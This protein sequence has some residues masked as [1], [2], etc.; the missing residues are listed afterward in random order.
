MKKIV[1]PISI[2]ML[3]LAMFV[4]CQRVRVNQQRNIVIQ[5]PIVDISCADPSIVKHE[6]MYYIFATVDPW[7]GE[8][9]VVLETTDFQN[10]ERKHISWPN[11][12]E[13]ISPTSRQDKVWA[14]G[15]I[16][17]KDS[18]FYMYVTVHNEIWAGV[19]NHPTG[20]WKNAK[21]DKSPLIK[22]DMF[23]EYHMIDAEPFIDDDGQ[24]YLYWGSGLDWK[25]GHCFI[26]RMEDDM[27]SFNPNEVQD[28]TPPNYF[29]APFMLKRNGKYYLMYSQGKCI[30]GTYKVRVSAG[31]MPYGPWTELTSSP[32]LATS[33]DSTTLGPGH[34][35]VF[36]EN[37]Q[38]YILYHRIRDNNNTL[39]RELAIDSL[40]FKG[41]EIL[42][43]VP[44]SLIN[45]P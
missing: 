36:N 15:V 14:P 4:G 32:I 37:G 13:C 41:T 1:A 17:G 45:Q 28:I 27:I 21:K 3:A 7:G 31:D 12:D 30:D 42:K 2:L 22:S 24:V 40:I 10:F 23:P 18:K 19:A 26:A 8:E 43:V 20:P 39:L 35:T 33:A 5:N 44:H 25:N 34:H 6:G 29:E 11:L 9:L 16:K 38:D